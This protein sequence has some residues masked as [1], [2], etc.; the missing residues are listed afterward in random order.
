MATSRGWYSAL[1]R[2]VFGIRSV[3]AFS[4]AQYKAMVTIVAIPV[5]SRDVATGI[6]PPSATERRG[7]GQ[8]EGGEHAVGQHIRV[9]IIDPERAFWSGD[10]LW[11][12]VGDGMMG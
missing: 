8:L 6:D 5:G 7:T 1:Q 10:E 12:E 4:S 11:P 2:G 3:I 9:I